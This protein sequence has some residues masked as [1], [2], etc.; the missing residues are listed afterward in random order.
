M[1]NEKKNLQLTPRAR[2]YSGFKFSR[3]KLF[4]TNSSVVVIITI[5][6]SL[7]LHSSTADAPKCCMKTGKI[8]FQLKNVE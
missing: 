5:I 3:I 6:Y 7:G 1:I 8:K 4:Q 2:S